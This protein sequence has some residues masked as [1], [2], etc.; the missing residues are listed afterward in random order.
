MNAFHISI[1]QRPRLRRPHPSFLPPRVL[2]M[3]NNQGVAAQPATVAAG[4]I[5][6][7][8]RRRAARPAAPVS[9]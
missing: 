8:L 1:H 7:E 9:G 6:E 3:R 4:M 5:A 2:E